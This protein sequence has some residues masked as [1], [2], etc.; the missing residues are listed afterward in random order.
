MEKL[1]KARASMLDSS[2]KGCVEEGATDSFWTGLEGPEHRTNV[3][4]TGAPSAPPFT[5]G[6][7]CFQFDSLKYLNNGKVMCKGG[8]S[9]AP[10][11]RK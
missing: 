2:R 6:F 9:P 8:I 3:G 11:L 10:P 4:G 7:I 1:L 5:A